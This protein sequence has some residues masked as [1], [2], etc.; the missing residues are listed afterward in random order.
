MGSCSALT[1]PNKL[2]YRNPISSL[3]MPKGSGLTKPMKLSADLADIVGKK[4]ASRA[5]CIKE[6]WAYLKKNNLQD[7]ANKQFFTPDKKMAKVF[8]TD[9]IR[10]F[11]TAKIPLTSNFSPPTKRW[12]RFSV[13]TASV[14]SAWPSFSPLTCHKKWPPGILNIWNRQKK[15]LRQ[16]G[17]R[18]K[19]R[20]KYHYNYPTFTMTVLSLLRT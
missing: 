11:G 4:E 13:P 14:P 15:I 5:E 6:L 16:R 7:P 10:A 12:L 3:I 1:A 8:G 17:T 19:K 20:R 18:E 9:R 2:L